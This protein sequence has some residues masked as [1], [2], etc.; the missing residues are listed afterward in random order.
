MQV[1]EYC[2]I[3]LDP[4]IWAQQRAFRTNQNIRGADNPEDFTFQFDSQTYTLPGDCSKPLTVPQQIAKHA[5]KSGMVFPLQRTGDGKVRMQLDKN[6]GRIQMVRI[7][8]SWRPD[9]APPEPT[10]PIT[11]QVFKD[12]FSGKEYDTYEEMQTAAQAH[13]DKLAAKSEAI[14]SSPADKK[15]KKLGEP[16]GVT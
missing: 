12:P 3:A 9:T 11:M 14:K 15:S 4:E 10:E 7:L 13:A 1:N 2:E 5:V 8:R 6:G 16:A